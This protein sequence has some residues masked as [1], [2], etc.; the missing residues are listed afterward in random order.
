M[1]EFNQIQYQNEYNKKNYDRMSILLPKGKKE[2]V[3][4]R[5]KS[6]NQSVNSY[7][8]ELIDTDF[9]GSDNNDGKI[10]DK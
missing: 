3:K 9:E 1:G 4:Q 6:K 5:A 2:Q 8:N 10:H 7:I